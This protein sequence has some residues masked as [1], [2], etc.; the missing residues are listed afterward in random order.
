MP[1]KQFFGPVTRSNGASS[2]SETEFGD[3]LGLLKLLPLLP[4]QPQCLVS[5]PGPWH[6]V[7]LL[8]TPVQ[9]GLLP[10]FGAAP[11][12]FRSDPRSPSS[13][14]SDA[15]PCTSGATFQDSAL[16]WQA[17]GLMFQG[18]SRVVSCK[19]LSQ[20]PYGTTTPTTSPLTEGPST[21]KVELSYWAAI[22]RI[23]IFLLS[24]RYCPSNAAFTP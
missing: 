22:S 19:A 17:A 24:L 3:C 20:D 9:M 7:R 11:W 12:S 5:D 18:S 1:R 21:P 13:P 23:D 4:A 14:C 2:G 15:G 16:S 8:S 10:S 6:T